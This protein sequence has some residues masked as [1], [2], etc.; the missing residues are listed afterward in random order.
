MEMSEFKYVLRKNKP[1]L[2]PDLLAWA[3][4][5]DGA[6]RR[7]GRTMVGKSEVS[8]VFL[9]L[10]HSFGRGAP[11]LWETMVFGGPH[12]GYQQQCGG[13]WEQA[14]AM[15]AEVVKMVKGKKG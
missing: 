14:E 8:T 1:V 9:G 2:E 6:N 10:D 5:F 12:G 7:V 11:V 13:N 4:W 15:H 3:K